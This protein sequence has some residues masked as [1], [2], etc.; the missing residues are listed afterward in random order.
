MLSCERL[1]MRYV[2]ARSEGAADHLFDALARDLH[3][4]SVVRL[5]D[6]SWL[7]CDELKQRLDSVL[8]RFR[9]R[10]GLV[11]KGDSC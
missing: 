7:S 9:D 6:T 2:D 8:D 4:V 5:T 1:Y 3:S 11:L 10:G